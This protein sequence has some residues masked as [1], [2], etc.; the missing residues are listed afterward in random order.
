VRESLSADDDHALGMRGAGQPRHHVVRGIAR[1]GAAGEAIERGAHIAGRDRVERRED[2]IACGIDASIGRRMIGARMPRAEIRETAD[3]AT[4]ARGIGAGN[5]A[6][7][8]R[9]EQRGCRVLARRC[10]D[11]R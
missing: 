1:T 6:L 7:D 8:V 3:V 4:D 11:L 9:I 2:E 5:A 10:S